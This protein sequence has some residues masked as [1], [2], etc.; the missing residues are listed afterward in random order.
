MAV[1]GGFGPRAVVLNCGLTLLLGISQPDG[2]GR[3]ARW[4]AVVIVVV[5]FLTLNYLWEKRYRSAFFFWVSP[6]CRSREN[7][8]NDALWDTGGVQS[9]ST[10]SPDFNQ[11]IT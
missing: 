11:G 7:W 8:W 9:R 2:D 4:G 5:L 6:G 3:A 10:M 1:G